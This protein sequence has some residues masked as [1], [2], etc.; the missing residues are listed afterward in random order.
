MV[1]CLIPVMLCMLQPVSV[2]IELDHISHISQHFSQVPTEYGYNMAALA[3]R[4]QIGRLSLTLADGAVLG[5]CKNGWCGG[6]LQGPRETFNARLS[7]TL[8]RRD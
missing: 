6:S 4:W 7:F 2:D 1:N 8:W 3:A 5:G